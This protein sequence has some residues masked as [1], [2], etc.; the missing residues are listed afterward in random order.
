MLTWQLPTPAG[1]AP[2]VTCWTPGQCN[3]VCRCHADVVEQPQSLHALPQLWGFGWP[4]SLSVLLGGLQ[5]RTACRSSCSHLLLMEAGSL[6]CGLVGVF[7]PAGASRPIASVGHEAAFLEH[8]AWGVLPAKAGLAHSRAEVEQ[9]AAQ[10]RAA[11][12]GDDALVSLVTSQPQH[13]G[14]TAWQ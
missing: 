3:H 7:C 4:Y 1:Q 14:A 2:L 10:L 12:S 8:N 6:R 11:G 9:A 13:H 5:C